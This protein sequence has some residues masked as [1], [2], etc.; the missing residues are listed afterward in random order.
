MYI[1][2]LYRKCYRYLSVF[3]A[4]LLLLGAIPLSAA[5]PPSESE[6][7]PWTN[8]FFDVLSNAWFY[9]AVRYVSERQL[10][11]GVAKN[12]FDPDSFMSRAMLVTVLWR[13]AGSPDASALPFQDVPLRKWFT[14]AVAWASENGVVRGVDK[15]RFAPNGNVTREQVA[16][17]LYRASGA[18]VSEETSSI[19]SGF[20]D[21]SSVS[22]WARE[23]MRWAVSEE[24][25]TG[26]PSV[27]GTL[28]APKQ[29]ATRAQVAAI[30]MRYLSGETAVP[31]VEELQYGVSGSGKY[32]LTA[33]RIGFGENVLLLNFAIHGWEDNFDADGAELV[34]IADALIGELATRCDE[35]TD[36]G[37]TVYVIRCANPDG[38]YL[39]TSCNGPGRCTTTYYSKGVLTSNGT[40]GIDMNRCFPYQ[41]YSMTNRRNYNGTQPLQCREAQALADFTQGVKGTGKNI[42]IDTHGWYDKIITSRSDSELFDAFHREFP[43]ATP[44][45]LIGGSGYYSAWAAFVAGYDEACLFELPRSIVSHDAFIRSKSTERFIRV[46]LDLLSH[47]GKPKSRQIPPLGDAMPARKGNAPTYRAT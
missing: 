15:Q 32:P 3:L 22:T 26:I 37:W 4:A 35:I 1:K 47:Y 19:L 17:L 6:D 33:C 2:L 39:G 42:C 46:I 8:P 14:Q 38:L 43:T 44:A 24:I 18:A 28:L 36:E 7:A 30:L 41:F 25:I 21:A 16:V 12:R 34:R 23:A 9:D 20:F 45:S 11:Q 31:A 27:S 40:Q 10:F 13:A 5:T 29:S